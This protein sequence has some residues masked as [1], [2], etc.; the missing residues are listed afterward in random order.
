MQVGS[1]EAAVV[2]AVVQL[3]KSLGKSVVAEG[4]ET[5]SHLNQLRDMGCDVGQG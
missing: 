4:F 3:G 5:P 1:K 2:R